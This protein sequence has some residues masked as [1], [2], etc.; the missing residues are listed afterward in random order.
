MLVLN[1]NNIRKTLILFVIILSMFSIKSLAIITPTPEFYVND[2]ANLLDA[3]TRDYIIKVNKNLYNQTGSQIVIVTVK[4]LEGNSIED[5]AIKLF[6]NFGIGDKSKNNGV[7]LL[8]AFE[9]REFRIEVGY[10]LEGILPDGKTGRIQDEYIIPYLRQNNWNDGIKNGFN[11]IADEVAKEYNIEIGNDAGVVQQS[12]WFK[13]DDP[14]FKFSLI[15]MPIISRFVGIIIA[16]VKKK[17]KLNK[18]VV[19]FYSTIYMIFAIGITF[20]LLKE[21]I[22]TVIFSVFDLIALILGLEI[23]NNNSSGGGHRRYYGGFSSRHSSFDGGSSFG[24]GG[25]SLG[26]GSS[27]SF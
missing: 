19:M 26:G 5:Y 1:K 14:C 6:R 7:L 13:E 21:I 22:I 25:S 18:K 23:Y 9:E 17:K 3:E 10:G 8:L 15:G 4:N 24:G 16:T 2:Y 12:S 27:R 20:F 11:A